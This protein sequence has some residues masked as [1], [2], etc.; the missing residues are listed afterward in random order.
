M[1]RIIALAA[2]LAASWS[3]SGC[4]GGGGGASGGPALAPSDPESGVFSGFVLDEDGEPVAGAQVSVEGIAASAVTGDSGYFVVSDPELAAAP[5]SSSLGARAG[6]DLAGDLAAAAAGSGRELS[7]LAPGHEPIVSTLQVGKG[8]FANLHL[9]PNGR[10]PELVLVSPSGE[11]LFVIAEDCG[12]PQVLVEGYARLRARLSQRL[13]V[14]LVIDRSGSTGRAAFDVDGDGGVDRV[15]DAEIAA[16]RCLVRG[17]DMTITRVAILQVNDAAETVLDFTSDHAEIDSKLGDIAVAAGGTNFDAAFQACRDHFI[18]L[19]GEDEAGA[20]PDEALALPAPAPQRAVVL[21]T[22][23]IP[24]S[25][26]VPRDVSDTNLTQSARDREAAIDSARELGAATGASLFAYAIL[27]AGDGSAR[28]TTLPHCVASCGGGRYAPIPT[29]EKLEHIL[30]GEPLEE[31]LTVEIENVTTGDPPL[32]A[33]LHPDGFFSEHMPVSAGGRGGGGGRDTNV[34]RVR[35]TALA[36]RAGERSVEE[37]VTVRLV[38]EAEARR[39]DAGELASAQAAPRPVAG[40]E[41]LKLPTGG[42]LRDRELHELLAHREK[43][44][45]ADAVELF[46]LD[47]FTAVDPDGEGSATVRAFVDFVFKESCYGS[48]FGYVV[49]DPAAPPQSAEEALDG[50]LDGQILFNSREAGAGACA[51]ESLP[52]GE[53][54]HE[55]ELPVGAVV[56]F[57]ILPNRTLAEYRADPGS[58]LR[59]LFTVPSLNPGGFDHVLTFRSAQGRTAAGDPSTVVHP[60]PLLI[61]AFEDLEIARRHSDQDFSDVVVTLSREIAG[62]LDILECE[63]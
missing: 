55:I 41:H 15:L 32:V 34:I 24:T 33:H 59:P 29:A 8:E 30:C 61:L 52:H 51:T 4:G 46:G 28:R 3:L 62:R 21:L 20:E 38:R 10:Q 7:V 26:G 39:L 14:V 23:G 44:E 48:D 43:G 19:G 22:D 1:R 17:L 6:E 56:A 50:V 37:S 53:A 60:G 35:L 40:L 18:T 2:A 31:L 58:G 63:E 54:R 11:K 13:D 5:Q 42:A 9:G 45:F 36:G 25:H 49:I 57:F 16:A 12:D 27:L 47:T